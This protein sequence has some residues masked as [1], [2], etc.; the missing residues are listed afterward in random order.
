MAKPTFKILVSLLKFDT[1]EKGFRSFN[2][3]NFG[4]IVEKVLKL[5]VVKV[6]VLRKSSAHRCGT[7]LSAES[8]D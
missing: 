1:I 6:G 4:L 7:F 2:K 5:L 8:S 3:S